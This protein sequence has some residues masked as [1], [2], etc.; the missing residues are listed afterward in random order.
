VPEEVIQD[1][2]HVCAAFFSLP[3]EEKMKVV[4]RRAANAYRA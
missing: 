1:M 3:I 2:R 4:A